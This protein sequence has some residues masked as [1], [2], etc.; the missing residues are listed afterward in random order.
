MVE[1]YQAEGEKGLEDQSRRP[2]K[3][4]GAKV[5]E[6]YENLILALRTKR[7]MGEKRIQYELIATI[8]SNF[9]PQYLEGSKTASDASIKAASGS[10]E[11]Q[12]I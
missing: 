6:E 9:Q 10:P 5:T 12:T 11:T 3:T 1:R 8:N 2:H 4:P 7:N